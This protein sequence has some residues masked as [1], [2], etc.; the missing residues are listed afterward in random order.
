MFSNLYFRRWTKATE[1]WQLFHSDLKSLTSWLDEAEYK[2]KS[3]SDSPNQDNV[4]KV[5]KFS[6]KRR[7]CIMTYCATC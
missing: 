2:L 1:Q 6:D 5:R 3:I 7:G 4:Y